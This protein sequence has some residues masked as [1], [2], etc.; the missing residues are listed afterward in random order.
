VRHAKL[1]FVLYRLINT[2]VDRGSDQCSSN[3]SRKHRPAPRES[4][5]SWTRFTE[6]RAKS[7]NQFMPL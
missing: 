6:G 2:V 3:V 7:K 1:S 4:S 5:L